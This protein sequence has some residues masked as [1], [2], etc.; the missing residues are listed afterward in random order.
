MD[1]NYSSALPVRLA[2][3]DTVIILEVPRWRCLARVLRRNLRHRGR[4]RGED[5]PNGCPEQFDRE[6]LRYIWGTEALSYRGC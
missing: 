1:G 3:A 5:L 6:L 4:V 2:V